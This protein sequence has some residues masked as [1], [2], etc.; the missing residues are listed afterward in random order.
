MKT[1]FESYST[2][3]EFSYHNLLDNEYLPQEPNQKTNES[4]C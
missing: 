2:N 1:L 3:A 4:G